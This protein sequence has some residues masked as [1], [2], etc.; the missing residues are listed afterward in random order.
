MKLDNITAIVVLYNP[1][2]QNLDQLIKTSTIFKELI[3]VNNSPDN[4]DII[5]FY[6][7]PMLP[8]NLISITNS[9]NFGIAK[10]LNIGIQKAQEL[11]YDWVV[12]LDQDSNYDQ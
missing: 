10:A 6:N 1:E 3:V 7:N 5:N 12:T 2:I 4:I 8:K 9:E 11:G